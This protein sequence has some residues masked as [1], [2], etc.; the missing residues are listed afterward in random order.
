MII[1]SK[2]WGAYRQDTTNL[3][4]L[5]FLETTPVNFCAHLWAQHSRRLRAAMARRGL[6]GSEVGITLARTKIDVEN[7]WVYEE[8]DLVNDLNG[9]FSI[10]FSSL[11]WGM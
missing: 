8:N 2:V 6:C 10:L 1:D 3:L 9:I 4:V 11:P 7:P 5:W